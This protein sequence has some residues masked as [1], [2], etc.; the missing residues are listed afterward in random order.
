MEDRTQALA[1]LDDDV[2]D[3]VIGGN[4]CYVYVSGSCAASGPIPL[5]F[6]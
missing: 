6:T 4:Y 1:G 5:P 3:G 2:L